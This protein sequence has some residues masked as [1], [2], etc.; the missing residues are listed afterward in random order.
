MG[1]WVWDGGR[2]SIDLLNTVRHRARSPRETL[3]TPADLA[4]W[5][6][7]ADLPHGEDAVGEAALSAAR[8]LR[9]AIDALT[10][11]PSA[12][13]LAG[14]VTLPVAVALVN[15]MAAD[16]PTGPRLALDGARPV[17]V[18]PEPSVAAALGRVALDAIDLLTGGERIGV[19]AADDCGVRFA[20]R[21]PAQ[22][23]QW[24]S[25][26]RCGNRSKARRHYTRSTT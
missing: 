14:E 17:A 6:R 21:S 8:R 4:V 26:R 13:E 10:G 16:A 25:M 18:P 23:R 12:E 3:R 24:C 7:E 9:A 20:D 19:C 22:N 2:L 15:A 1:D 5:L 11:V